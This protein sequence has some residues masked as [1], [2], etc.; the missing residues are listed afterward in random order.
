M[1]SWQYDDWFVCVSYEINSFS[2]SNRI[3]AIMHDYYKKV[4]SI[5]SNKF[6]KTSTNAIDRKP[7][8]GWKIKIQEFNSYHQIRMQ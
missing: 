5:V 6:N 7:L 2:Y 1:L 4:P 8:I 3:E